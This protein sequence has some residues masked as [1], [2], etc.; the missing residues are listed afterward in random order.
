MGLTATAIH[1]AGHAVAAVD[2]AIPFTTATIEPFGDRFGA[3]AWENELAGT[4]P[5]RWTVKHLR[6]ARR[7]IAFLYAGPVAE[8][9]FTKSKEYV[10]PRAWLDFRE[11]GD[12]ALLVA[13]RPAARLTRREGT[14]AAMRRAR[15]V[16]TSRW[17]Q[18]VQVAALL[19]AART[20]TYEQVARAIPK[21]PNRRTCT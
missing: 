7:T 10:V 8:L 5:D 4:D 2:L 11:A 12:F 17:P 16:V 21:P 3:V 6:M 9:I 18:V 19:E 13:A 1:E 20:V 15:R 14:T